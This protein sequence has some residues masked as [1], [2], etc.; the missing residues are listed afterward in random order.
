MYVTDARPDYSANILRTTALPFGGTNVYRYHRRWVEESTWQSLKD[1]SCVGK[2]LLISYMENNDAVLD[3]ASAM[4]V[5]FATITSAKTI[6]DFAII[7][8]EVGAFARPEPPAHLSEPGAP[9][10]LTIRGPRAGKF[11]LTVPDAVRPQTN[12]ADGWSHCAESLSEMN[13]FQDACFVFLEEMV[14]RPGSSKVALDNGRLQISKG[15]IIDFTIHALIPHRLGQAAQFEVETNGDQVRLA[16]PKAL[17]FG[18]RFSTDHIPVEARGQQS[19][20]SSFIRIHPI[21]PTVGPDITIPIDFDI[22]LESR[23]L[24]YGVPGIAASLAAMAGVVG[25]AVPLW[26]R[27][28]MVFFGSAGVAISAARKR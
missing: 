10:K 19:R 2:A 7:D 22:N 24:D 5:R 23:I 15:E 27:L 8:A 16:R 21:S 11:L 14:R 6:G 12:I 1:G 20:D 25:D 17:T 28:L 3:S 9:A 4:P 26:V 13:P 18:H